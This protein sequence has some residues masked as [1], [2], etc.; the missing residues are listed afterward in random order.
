MK[1]QTPKSAPKALT[2]PGYLNLNGK[3]V[4]C[5]VLEDKRRVLL[6]RDAMMALSG[7][8]D[9]IGAL[10]ATFYNNRRFQPLVANDEF[11]IIA[12]DGDKKRVVDTAWFL[13]VCEAFIDAGKAGELSPTQLHIADNAE[14]FMMAFARVGL[15][16]LRRNK[17][18]ET[19]TGKVDAA[20][21]KKRGLR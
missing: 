9:R 5:F 2:P 1:H 4:E 14:R 6:H 12:L 21:I 11:E 18:A 8:D 20:R 3:R 15:E 13:S 16:A 19:S 7:T 10:L 17:A